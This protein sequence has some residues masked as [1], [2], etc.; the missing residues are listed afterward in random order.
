MALDKK[1]IS[2]IENF[3]Y[4]SRGFFTNYNDNVKSTQGIL[5]SL[6]AE[7]GTS[8][9]IAHFTNI[10]ID[11]TIPT[12][13]SATS[14]T[15][16]SCIITAL[17]TNT[18][19]IKIGGSNLTAISGINLAAGENIELKINNTNLLYALATVDGEDV[20]VAYFN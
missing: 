2:R 18:G 17:S 20:T 19:L 3:A 16:K 10:D 13:L 9:S 6:L 15:C 11:D 5:L 7:L 4:A 1:L 8:T 14:H 12:Q